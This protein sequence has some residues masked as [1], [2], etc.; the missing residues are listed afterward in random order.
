M[1]GTLVCKG[2]STSD[3]PHRMSRLLSAPEQLIVLRREQL[4]KLAGVSPTTALHETNDTAHGHGR[5]YDI[6]SFIARNG[7]EVDGPDAYQ[8]GRRWTFR[9]SPMCEHHGDGPYLIQF[10]NGA[11]SAGC[12]HDSCKWRWCDFRAKYDPSRQS[13]V[14][15]RD[16]NPRPPTAREVAPYT[17]FP[18]TALPAVVAD[19]VAAGAAAIGCDPAFI[20]L[21]LLACLARSIGNSRVIRLKRTWTEPAIFW[22]AIVGKSGTHK[23]PAIEAAVGHLQ[24]KQSTA[25]ADYKKS[26]IEYEEREA[27]YGRQYKR[28]KQSNNK[29]T[30]SP[31]QRPQQ[32]V[33]ER[34]ITVDTTIEALA[35]ILNAQY[36]GILVVR[37]E[38]AGWL[39]GIAEYKSGKGSDL[40]HWL[41]SWS[42]V[43]M[44][45]DRKTGA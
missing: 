40:G 27:I 33:C 26:L 1:P 39:G 28:W 16:P 14:T 22:A 34:Y 32:P 13:T 30:D 24:R 38:L 29:A 19:Y 8:G 44:T 43:P 18:V 5:P 15:G 3:R 12:H 7:F 10:S 37:D 4:E 9:R 41:A 25:I 23:T 20:A 6:D 17:P 31:P 45:I 36:H 11:L 42:G 21:P 35:A 2:D